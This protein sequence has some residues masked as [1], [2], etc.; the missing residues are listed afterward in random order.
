MNV[1][2]RSPVGEKMGVQEFFSG[3]SWRW[4]CEICK[5]KPVSLPGKLVL[6]YTDLG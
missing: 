2:L 3:Q 6:V 4:N 5:S 1:F